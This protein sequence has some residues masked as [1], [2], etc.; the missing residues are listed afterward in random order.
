MQS[1]LSP[2]LLLS[3][4]LLV[5]YLRNHRK[6]KRLNPVFSSKNFTFTII[7]NITHLSISFY[8]LTFNNSWSY[9]P[10]LSS[11]SLIICSCNLA[12][13][14]FSSSLVPRGYRV[15]WVQNKNK[16]NSDVRTNRRKKVLG[17]NAGR[18][19]SPGKS[20]F[21]LKSGFPIGKQKN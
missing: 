21:I 18:P 1:N 16:L 5:S 8:N 11:R 17:I 14:I 7:F 2:F 15:V 3:F 19:E 10:G 13:T 6:A 12:R 20:N 4:G 9:S